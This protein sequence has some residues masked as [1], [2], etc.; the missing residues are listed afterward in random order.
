MFTKTRRL[1][2]CALI[3]V[4][5]WIFV[6]L[7]SRNDGGFQR[8]FG[9][10]PQ[11][12][13]AYLRTCEKTQ[14]NPERIGQTIGDAPDSVGYHKRDGILKLNSKS[15]EY[16]AAVDLAT[17]DLNQSQ[18]ARWCAALTREGFAPFYRHIGKWQ[19]KQHI[20]AIFAPLKMKP[21]LQEQVREFM[22]QRHADKL[23]RL[24]WMK[25]FEKFNVQVR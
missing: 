14:I 25:E 19:H 6:M 23:P 4:A 7:R 20:H 1:L 5:L 22:A 24:I 21:Q 12:F 9:M 11:A 13:A 15:I 17:A 8:P 16:C 3:F 10:A 18:I 2:F